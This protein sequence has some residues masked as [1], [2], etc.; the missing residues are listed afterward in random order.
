MIIINTG[1][2]TLE[3]V[4]TFLFSLS[5]YKKDIL[6]IVLSIFEP[7]CENPTNL[8]TNG[9]KSFEFSNTLYRVAF[10]YVCHHRFN[11]I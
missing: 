4:F 11:T 7:C 8:Q 1:S 9:S 5:S 6:S 10:F 2:M 3:R